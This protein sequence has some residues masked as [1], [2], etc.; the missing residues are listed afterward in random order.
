MGDLVWIKWENQADPLEWPDTVKF[1]CVHCRQPIAGKPTPVPMYAEDGIVVC[2]VG[3]CCSVQCAIVQCGAGVRPSVAL[4]RHNL[5]AKLGDLLCEMRDR[6]KYAYPIIL[7]TT[8]AGP[9]TYL[10][11]FGG[12]MEPEEFREG[13][14]DIFNVPHKY[15]A[16]VTDAPLGGVQM[17]T[18]SGV[19]RTADVTQV[20]PRGHVPSSNPLE[21]LRRTKKKPASSK[22]TLDSFFK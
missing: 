6:P 16:P 20:R 1:P 9:R 4:K 12:T 5:L 18:N 10:K 21:G 14:Y 8:P 19:R 7:S 22:Y 13:F 3:Y 17:C 11:Q 2:R 15:T